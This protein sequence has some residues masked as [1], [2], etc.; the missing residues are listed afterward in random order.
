MIIVPITVYW[1]DQRIAEH[2]RW[3]NEQNYSFTFRS[4]VDSAAEFIN[5]TIYPWNNESQR[6]AQTLL[7]EGETSLFL[8]DELDMAH[9]IQL[10]DIANKVHV[11]PS[12]FYQITQSQRVSVSTNLNAL[13]EKIVNAYVLNNTSVTNGVGPS[14]W[15]SGP[16]PPNEQDLQDATTIAANLAG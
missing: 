7:G 13:G 5:G 9:T 14:F 10:N 2:A 1:A 4:N 16:S 15:Y 11:I 6:S 3:D 12:T 8:L